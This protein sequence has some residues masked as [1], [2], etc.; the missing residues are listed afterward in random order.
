[1]L[2]GKEGTEV[3]VA[4]LSFNQSAY[5]KQCLDSIFMQRC[6][7]S[8]KVFVYDDVSSDNS[9]DI[10]LEY[11]KQYGDR[12]MIF[13]PETNQFSQ[14]KFNTFYKKMTS[15]REYKYIAM[16][17]ADDYWSRCDK[18]QKQY[19][20]LEKNK[21]CSIC[22]CATDSID[23]RHQRMMGRAPLDEE[24]KVI[25]GNRVIVDTL[26]SSCLFG[27]NTYF[28]KNKYFE[29]VDMETN[30]WNYVAGDMA[31][32]LYLAT[33]GSIYYLGECMAVKRR[34][35]RG[36][37][38]EKK[39]D[40]QNNA[41]AIL[42]KNFK[43]DI[44]WAQSF[45]EISDKY[46]DAVQRYIIWRKIRLYYIRKGNIKLNQYVDSSNGK[47]YTRSLYQ[48]INRW[49]VRFVKLFYGNDE[50]KF[51]KKEKQWMENEWRRL[52]EKEV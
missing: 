31:F 29:D 42:E 37:I 51:V 5:I 3:L 33:Q 13:Q 41:K 22:V 26:K 32:I 9:W 52:Q 19:E 30:F 40:I 45:N 12:I 44:E 35:N 48:K 10:I 27:T 49:Y 38:S 46:S 50:V 18:L 11:K 28:M 2:D 14:G 24:D 16:C 6:N 20:C 15:M 1:M 34:F 43:A 23:D 36:S 8:Y 4:V 25:T 21:S 7:F 17:E 47:L 39:Y